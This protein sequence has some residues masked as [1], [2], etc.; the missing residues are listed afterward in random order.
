MS[1]SF[2]EKEAYLRHVDVA[3][4]GA[5]LVGLNAALRLRDRLPEAQIVVGEKHPKLVLSGGTLFAR[6]CSTWQLTAECLPRVAVSP[7][8]TAGQAESARGDAV[9]PTSSTVGLGGRRRGGNPQRLS[10][11]L[12]TIPIAHVISAHLS[13]SAYAQGLSDTAQPT[14]A[15]RRRLVTW[16]NQKFSRSEKI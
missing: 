14:R 11:L 9:R 12:G 10:S 3:V 6:H 15:M 1:F 2:W 13:S 4:I 8:P 5:G 16:S 7:E